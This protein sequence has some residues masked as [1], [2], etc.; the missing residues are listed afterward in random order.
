MVLLIDNNKN[1]IISRT[2]LFSGEVKYLSLSQLFLFTFSEMHGAETIS[3]IQFKLS[4]VYFFIFFSEIIEQNRQFRRYTDTVLKVIKSS[5]CQKPRD[6]NLTK[7][8]REF[9]LSG[10]QPNESLYPIHA[11]Q[12]LVNIT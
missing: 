8:V 9:N 4:C 6:L 3:L 10:N 7:K 11:T 5:L 12:F 1:F 2:N